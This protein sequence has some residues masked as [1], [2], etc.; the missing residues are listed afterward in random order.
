MPSMPDWGDDDAELVPGTARFGGLNTG[1]QRMVRPQQVY[2]SRE[3]RG[4][5]LCCR[6]GVGRLASA[7][8]RSL[9]DGVTCSVAH[10]LRLELTTFLVGSSLPWVWSW[11]SFSSSDGEKP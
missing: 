6:V 7:T 11:V 8:A 10:G 2:L 9:C 3:D 1:I 5:G 4:T